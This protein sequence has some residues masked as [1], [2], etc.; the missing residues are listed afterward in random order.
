MSE[1]EY[2]NSGP[3]LYCV[4]YC[5]Y[6]VFGGECRCLYV[7]RVCLFLVFVYCNCVEYRTGFGKSFDASLE[8]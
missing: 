2:R 1:G 7:L 8:V 5:V 3:G 6:S 4:V